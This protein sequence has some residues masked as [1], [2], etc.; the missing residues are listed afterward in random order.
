VLAAQ[1]AL[2]AWHVPLEYTANKTNSIFD[3]TA[4]TPKIDF[5]DNLTAFIFN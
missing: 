2:L 1:A 5:P 3:D 4:N